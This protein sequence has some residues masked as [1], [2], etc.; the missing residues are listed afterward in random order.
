MVSPDGGTSID[1]SIDVVERLSSNGSKKPAIGWLFL[2]D[3]GVQERLDMAGDRAFQFVQRQ[4]PRD[5][6]RRLIRADTEQFI[7]QA[8]FEAIHQ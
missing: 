5:G 7:E 3:S 2:R 8:G 4:L 6:R 1:P